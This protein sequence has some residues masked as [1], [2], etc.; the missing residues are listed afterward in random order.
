MLKHVTSHTFCNLIGVPR[1]WCT[2]TKR[3]RQSPRPFLHVKNSAEGAVCFKTS[4]KPVLCVPKFMHACVQVYYC[5]TSTPLFILCQVSYPQQEI[6]KLSQLGLQYELVQLLYDV[7][8]YGY[9]MVNDSSYAVSMNIVSSCVIIISILRIM[10]Y[11]KQLMWIACS[12]L[13]TVVQLTSNLLL[14]H[15]RAPPS[16][17]IFGFS[18]Q[19]LS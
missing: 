4:P 14:C 12:A 13:T 1:S 17:V 19:F 15:T 7:A 10:A 2:D 8:I 9:L 18:V 3:H 11:I 16:F 6:S 5:K